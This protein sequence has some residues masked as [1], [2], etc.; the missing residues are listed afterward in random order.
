[1][2]NVRNPFPDDTAASSVL[3]SSAYAALSRTSVAPDVI[4]VRL[5]SIWRLS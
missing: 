5:C 3:N 1:M 4:T 2:M